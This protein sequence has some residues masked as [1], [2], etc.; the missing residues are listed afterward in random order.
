MTYPICFLLPENRAGRLSTALSAW[1]ILGAA[2]EHLHAQIPDS[3]DSPD[4]VITADE[5]DESGITR[6]HDLFPLFNH[7][8]GYSING[9]DWTAAAGGLSV[10]EEAGWIVM[11]DNHP[12][13]LSTPGG[14]SFNRLPVSLQEIEKVIVIDTPRQYRGL[15]ADRGLIHIITEKSRMGWTADVRLMTG[16][17]INDPGPYEFTNLKSPNEE[18]IGPDADIVLGHRTDRWHLQGSGSVQRHRSTDVPI[19]RR[20]KD[21]LFTGNSFGSPTNLTNTWHVRSGYHGSHLALNMQGGF[22]RS[23]DFR[24]MRSFGREIP[25]MFR[26]L[27]GGVDAAWNAGEKMTVLLRTTFDDREP[28]YLPNRIDYRFDLRQ[29]DLSH[30][31]GLVRDSDSRQLSAGILIE[32]SRAEGNF[33]YPPDRIRIW[34]FHT[35]WIETFSE[36]VSLT[37]EFRLSADGGSNAADDERPVRNQ[38]H[39]AG[40]RTEWRLTDRQFLR[41]Y[42]SYSERLPAET[43]NIWFWTKRGYGGLSPFEIGTDAVPER[44]TTALTSAGVRWEYLIPDLLN[45]NLH[46]YH[47]RTTGYFLSRQSYSI[48][49]PHQWFGHDGVRFYPDEEAAAAGLDMRLRLH[50]TDRLSHTLS[51]GIR[52]ITGA[53]GEMKKALQEIPGRRFRLA[54]SYTPADGFQLWGSLGIKSAAVWHEFD[55]VDGEIYTDQQ[56]L[57][58]GV[59]SNRTGSAALLDAGGRK[60]LLGGRLWLSFILK[61]LLNRSYSHHP[62]GAGEDLALYVQLEIGL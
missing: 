13:S 3:R 59:Y 44:R 54:T 33:E 56:Q 12:V 36:K 17:E 10:Y 7:W 62:A 4:I 34:S 2:A 50:S 14:T 32:Q 28:D 37:A 26:N 58:E 8:T 51:M 16:N 52:T 47:S 5:I 42:L 20:I 15:T 31:A 35:Q 55:D 41:P 21:M 19:E 6:L 39:T 11:I 24:F 43:R 57:A 38:A 23:R 45:I 29:V 1:L 60:S 61:N 18:R 25:V 48:V 22:V 46:G 49:R 27:Y 9:Q 40:L 53:T 30:H